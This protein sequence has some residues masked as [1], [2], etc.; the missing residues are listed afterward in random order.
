[1][2]RHRTGVSEINIWLT[3]APIFWTAGFF[4]KRQSLVRSAT[5]VVSTFGCIKACPQTASSSEVWITGS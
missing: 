2:R 4:A 1:M 3:F 5:T